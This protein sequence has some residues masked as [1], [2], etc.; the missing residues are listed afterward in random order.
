ME[1]DLVEGG[2][3]G[4]RVE[5]GHHVEEGERDKSPLSFASRPALAFVVDGSST[6]AQRS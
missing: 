5:V 3:R 2:A 4:E 6:H 1:G